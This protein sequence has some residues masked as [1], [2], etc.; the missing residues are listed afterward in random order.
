MQDAFASAVVS[1][2]RDGIPDNPRAW[3][4]TGG[5][6]QGD[7]PAAPGAV[8][9]RPHRTPGRAGPARRPGA[10]GGPEEGSRDDRLRLIFT[11]CHPALAPDARVALTLRTLGGLTTGEIAW[12]FLVGEATMG[13]RLVR[14][15]RKI[16][17]AHI[18]YRV[19]PDDA[20]PERLAG[21]LSGALPRLQRGLRGRGGRPAR[22]G[23]AVQ[24]GHPPGPPAGRP[25]ARRARRPGPA[26]PHAAARRPAGG[27][28]RRARRLRAARS[29]GPQPLG[30]RPRPARASTPSTT[31]WRCDAPAPTSCRRRSPRPRA[32]AHRGRDRLAPDRRPV[33]GA[34]P[35]HALPRRGAEP[36]GGGG[37]ADGPDAGLAL[38]APLLSQ[39]ALAGY[40]PLHAAHAELLRRAGDTGGRGG[41]LPPGD[42]AERQ[43]R[44]APQ[45][46]RRL[47]A[48]ADLN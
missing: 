19:P 9:R 31:R 11:C 42:R 6:P 14:A 40:Q 23:R 47:G 39:A 15:K 36:G 4:T 45:L 5:P 3:V 13:Q 41:R 28:R 8:G 34:G 17:A 10:P 48:R 18:P 35:G 24:R 27:P 32:G 16:A 37:F 22:A 2:P 33:R 7:R 26:R 43:R 44:R 12:A 29:P 20:L 1:W 21:V 38:L 30:R 46:E 25:H